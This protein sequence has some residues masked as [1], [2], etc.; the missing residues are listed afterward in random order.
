MRVRRPSPKSSASSK[1]PNGTGWSK[2]PERRRPLQ[3]TST[4]LVLDLD[5]SNENEGHRVAVELAALFRA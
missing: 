1:K 4:S 5:R 2:K 3:G